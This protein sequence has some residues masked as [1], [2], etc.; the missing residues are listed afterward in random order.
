MFE[1][2]QHH[3]GHGGVGNS[4]IAG[5]RRLAVEADV[6]RTRGGGFLAVKIS[7][8]ADQLARRWL[9]GSRR[10]SQAP[11]PGLG[12][13]SFAEQK[14]MVDRFGDYLVATCK[15]VRRLVRTAAP[16]LEALGVKIALVVDEGVAEL[17][18]RE[19][20]MRVLKAD[21]RRLC[22]RARG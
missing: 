13:R 11:P 17:H 1:A 16:D 3:P 8:I 6:S 22:P 10:R 4:W 18:G 9:M 2:L 19:R 20:C 15:A 7:L 21:A 14:K 5:S 12:G